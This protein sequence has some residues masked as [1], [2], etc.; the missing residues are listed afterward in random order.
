MYLVRKAFASLPV[1]VLVIAVGIGLASAAFQDSETDP[2]SEREPGIDNFT[3]DGEFDLVGY[4][5][6]T[7]AFNAAPPVLRG[8]DLELRVFG[9]E[10]GGEVAI[11]LIP[12][13]DPIQELELVEVDNFVTEPV[14]LHAGVIEED[15]PTVVV[16]LPADDEPDGDG[17]TPLGYAVI[18]T[19]C[20]DADGQ[21]V[22]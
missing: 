16:V 14:V 21:P 20:A 12:R 18:R 15:I 2:R 8:E 5:S 13:V 22:E 1:V 10:V 19:T 9:C 3:V 7:G 4:V 6:G 11:E 17:V